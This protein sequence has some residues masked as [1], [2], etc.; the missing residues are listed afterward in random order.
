MEGRDPGRT[1]AADVEVATPLRQRVEIA[2]PTDSA[3][4]SPITVAR[5]ALYVETEDKMSALDLETGKLR[6]RVDHHGAYSSP[7][8]AGAM[9]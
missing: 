4:G 3:S 6:W 9:V 7:A 5:G 2:I 1:R 8:V